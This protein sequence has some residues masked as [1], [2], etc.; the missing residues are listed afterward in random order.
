MS[1]ELFG[2]Q[3]TVVSDNDESSVRNIVDFV[4]QRLEEI[5]DS[6]SRIK[7]DQIA[8]LAALNIAEELFA[9]RSKNEALK[10]S[11]KTRSAKLLSAI[12]KMAQDIDAAQSAGSSPPE[13]R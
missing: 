4:N 1:L 9:E 2:Q 6:T 7:V 3:F 8:L 5:R 11:V 10:A 13:P 12:D